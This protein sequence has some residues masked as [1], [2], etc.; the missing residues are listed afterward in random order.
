M[1]RT[2]KFGRRAAQSGRPKSLVLLLHGYGADSADLLGLADQL[3]PHLPDTSFVAPDAPERV[4][5]APYGY[6]WFSIPRFDGSSEETMRAGLARSTE[7]LTEFLIQR[8]AYDKVPLEA[9]ALLG[10]SQGAMMAMHVAPRLNTSIA[11]VI[12]ISGRLVEPERLEAEAVSKPPILL[13]H[14]TEDQVVPYGNMAFAGNE[15]TKA[16]FNVYAH[17]MEGTGHGIAPD[18]LQT[19]LGFLDNFLPH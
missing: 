8:A 7:D 14:G 12:A 11:A 3:A 2:L 1:A 15:L 16:G 6:Q 19:A 4:P 17:V 9:I 10:F 13:V 5:G 18:G